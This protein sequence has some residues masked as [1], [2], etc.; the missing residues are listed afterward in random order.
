MLADRRAGRP[1]EIDF[2]NGAIVALGDK[3]GA[4]AT[5]NRN[6]VRL[7]KA[8]TRAGDARAADGRARGATP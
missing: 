2:I 6:L 4:P 8:A 3:H 1:T 7:V 5:V